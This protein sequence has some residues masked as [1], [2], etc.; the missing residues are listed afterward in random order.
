MR[1]GSA[2]PGAASSSTVW[3]ASLTESAEEWC[4]RRLLARIHRYTLKRL[5]SEIKPVSIAVYQRY[6]FRWQGLGKER[7]QGGEALAAVIGEL[8]GLAL[9]AAVWER[10]IL[11]ARLVDY[12]QMQMDELAVA[13]RI[14][15]FRPMTRQQWN[16]A[17][18]NGPQRGRGTA[19]NSP[20][21]ILPRETLPLWRGMT[22]KC[23]GMTA[24]GN[25]AGDEYPLSAGAGRIYELLKAR[26]ALFFQELVQA[27][28]LLRVQTEDA[29][30]ELVAGGLVTSDS[31]QGLR[32]LVTPPS[33][34]RWSYGGTRA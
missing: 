30:A 16:Q 27:S 10:Q 14:A 23:R 21:V 34:R 17:V 7:R 29:L 12:S 20:I 19:A 5:R 31:F 1:S 26:G 8:Q 9:L 15:W 24:N 11:P 2:A 22:A 18:E 33:R 13:G 28:G 32:V 6:L 3:S 25:S 4:D